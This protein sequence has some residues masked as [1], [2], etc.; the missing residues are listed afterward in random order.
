MTITTATIH[1]N[2]L[3]YIFDMLDKEG[4]S[5]FTQEEIRGL[6]DYIFDCANDDKIEKATVN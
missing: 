5:T 4:K 6:I 1:T 2:E 3:R